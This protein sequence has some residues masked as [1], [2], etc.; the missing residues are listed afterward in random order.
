MHCFLLTCI[1]ID[2]ILI[3]VEPR[4]I[5]RVDLSF[6]STPDISAEAKDLISR[7]IL[8]FQCISLAFR[9]REGQ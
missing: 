3:K 6:P 2:H 5:M 7:V 1:F 9:I 8:Y 4:R